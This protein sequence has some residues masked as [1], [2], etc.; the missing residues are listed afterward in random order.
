MLVTYNTQTT[1]GLVPFTELM[2]SLNLFKLLATDEEDT[3]SLLSPFQIEEEKFNGGFAP[4]STVKDVGA[5]M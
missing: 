2:M 4:S 1:A 5:V 3:N